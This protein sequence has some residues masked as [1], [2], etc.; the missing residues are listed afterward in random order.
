[1]V[2]TWALQGDYDLGVMSR[3]GA[4]TPFCKC[5]ARVPARR[6]FVVASSLLRCN[7][8]L[9]GDIWQVTPGRRSDPAIRQPGGRTH[10]FVGIDLT[11]RSCAFLPAHDCGSPVQQH[12]RS[13]LSRTSAHVM[14]GAGISFG[15]VGSDSVEIQR[16]QIAE[17]RDTYAATA[18]AT[19]KEKDQEG[20]NGTKNIGA[21]RLTAYCKRRGGRASSI[22]PPQH[23]CKRVAQKLE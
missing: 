12:P 9:D 20:K 1:M 16:V 5:A 2:S 7:N 14:L 13:P 18:T 22:I 21:A 17:K 6:S 19:W 23:R 3:A 10:R 4:A 8:T 15:G 11:L